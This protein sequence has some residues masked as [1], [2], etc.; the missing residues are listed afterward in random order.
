MASAAEDLE[1][2]LPGV[3]GGCGE[4]SADGCPCAGP[5]GGLG[6]GGQRAEGGGGLGCGLAVSVGDGGVEGD[7]A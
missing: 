7:G 1:L 2:P 4:V 3:D 6:V 5:G